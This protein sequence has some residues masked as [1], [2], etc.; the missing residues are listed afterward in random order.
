MR[1]VMLGAL[2]AIAVAAATLDA[3][4]LTPETPTRFSSQTSYALSI[5]TRD[6]RQFITTPSWVGITWEGVWRLHPRT[7]VGVAFGV[8]DFSESMSGTSNF[9]WGAA[10]GQQSRNLLV[11]TIMATS[12][13]YPM[14]ERISRLHLGLDGGIVV[15]E[16]RYTLAASQDVRSAYHLAFAPEA[17]WQFHLV[18]GVDGMV[19]TRYTI[20]VRNGAYIGGAQ[21]FPYATLS[22]GVIE[23]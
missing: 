19:S 6:T 11:G 17:G 3:Q 18:D 10:T 12:R 8:H 2:A 22:F 9:T 14:P 1:S 20:P 4:E 13:W 16:E 7:G 15:S 5:P 23:R 21:S